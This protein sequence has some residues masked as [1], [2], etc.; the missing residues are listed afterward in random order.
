MESYKDTF[1]DLPFSQRN[2]YQPIPEQLKLEEVSEEQRRLIERYIKKEIDDHTVRWWFEE[3]WKGVAEDI[4]V[5]I[6]KRS[7]DSFQNDVGHFFASIRDFVYVSEFLELFDLLEFLCLDKNCSDA[8]KVNL[9]ESFEETHSAYRIVD[10]TKIVAIGNKESANTYANAIEIS[11]D[12][13]SKGARIHLID[14][15]KHLKDRKYSVSVHASICAVESI[16]KKVSPNSS[17]LGK[18]L[19]PLLKRGLINPQ[20][21]EAM[22]KLN[23]YTNSEGGVRHALAVDKDEAHVNEADAL[24]MLGVCASLVTYLLL[25]EVDLGSTI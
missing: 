24:F 10:Q 8:L 1:Q 7:I 15:G 22:E 3:N 16:A 21:K 19:G 6:L 14:A 5:R 11:G 23:A 9:T 4:H 25:R 18:A 13:G 20:L 17:T 12:H 2:G